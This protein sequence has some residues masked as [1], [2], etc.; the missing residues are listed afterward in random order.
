MKKLLCPIFLIGIG[1]IFGVIIMCFLSMRASSSF[2]EIVRLNYQQEQ[3]IMAIR[4]KKSGN[5]HQAVIHYSNL[6]SVTSSPGLYSFN[7]NRDYWTIGFPLSSLVL[8]KIDDESTNKSKDFQ[9]GIN[10]GMLADVLEK[11]GRTQKAMQEYIRAAYLLGCKDDII[12]T[13]EILKEIL[14]FED[15]LLKM[16]SMYTYPANQ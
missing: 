10:R 7:N 4:A 2:L 5:I 14:S 12:K 6:V 15:E 16:E 9:E 13:K 8:S 1:F 11:C 3:Q